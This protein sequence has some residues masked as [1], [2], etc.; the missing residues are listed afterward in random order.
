MVVY[1][2]R[3][4]RLCYDCI[5]GCENM[6]L[7][8]TLLRAIDILDLLSKNKDGYTLAQLSTLLDSPKSSVFDIMKTLVYKNMVTEENNLGNTRYKIGLQ[9][10]LI[11]SS[12]L[13][14]FDI[15][16]IA[17]NDLTE[18]AEKLNGTTFMAVLDDYKVTYIYKY[19]S[20]NSV[21]TTANIGTKNPLHST[22]LGKVLIAFLNEN[23]FREALKTIDYEAYTP[24]TITS[25]EKYIEEIQKTRRLG[26]AV[27]NRENSLYQFC[28]AA[29]IR[30]YSGQVIAAISCTGLYEEFINF[31]DLGLVVKETADKI[32][33]KLGHQ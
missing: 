6:K 14:D 31:N 3:Y 18:L 17:R 1:I 21:I 19:E 32:S 13:R 33:A 23:N 2:Y 10:F 11:G 28:A 26:Y 27:D 8:R 15:V 16:N 5:K 30:D 29:P 25:P 20:H 9:S 24:Y 7:N 22:G 12:F 4:S